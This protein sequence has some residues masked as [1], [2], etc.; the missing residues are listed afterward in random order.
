ML[1]YTSFFNVFSPVDSAIIDTLLAKSIH[2]SYKKGDIITAEGQIQR[3]L[4]LVEKGVQMSYFNHD[5]KIQ[6]MAFTYPPSLT[7]I[8]D[9]FF[10][11]QPSK[12]NLIA[13]TDSQLWS[14]SYQQINELFDENQALERVFRKMTEAILVGIIQR[15]LELQTLTIEER[16]R[17][18]A[19]RSPHLF[20]LVP[21]KYIASYLRINSTNF[22]K[23]YNSIKI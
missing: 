22:S 4:Y 9:A 14:I 8:P 5:G 18:F 19:Q 12:F 15:H 2:K 11:Q 16:F 17:I 3:N 6:V 13:L 7:G 21:H 23:L 20:Q 1:D 10:S